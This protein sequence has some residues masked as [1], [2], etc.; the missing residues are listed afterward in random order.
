MNCLT[1]W[2]SVEVLVEAEGMRET[3]LIHMNITNMIDKNTSVCE[4]KHSIKT[5]VSFL[6]KRRR[7]H[8]ALNC[9]LLALYNTCM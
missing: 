8:A 7:F 5:T 6:N 1:I 4:S 2:F 3:Q 9:V